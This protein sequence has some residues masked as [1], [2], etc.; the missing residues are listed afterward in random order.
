M[1]FNGEDSEFLALMG[2]GAK[3]AKK[4]HYPELRRRLFELERVS[5]VLDHAG[6]AIFLISLPDGTVEF[7]NKAAL[8]LLGLER[9]TEKRKL[10]EYLKASD[11]G[12]VTL[13]SLFHSS[14]PGERREI[15]SLLTRRGT[16]RYEA[17]FQSVAKGA[18]RLGTLILRDHEERISAEEKLA[19]TLKT[20][21]EERIRTVSLTASL[22]EMKDSY[23]GRNQRG[24][25]SLAREIGSQLGLPN[26][27]IDDL[28]TA[29]LLH[30]VGMMGIPTEVLCIPGPLRPVD[31]RL[32]QEH[33]E[34]GRNL[35]AREGFSE[36]ILDGALRHHERMDGSGYPGGLRGEDIPFIAR[37]IGLAD[38][39]EAMMNHRPYRP[40]HSRESTMR[41][42]AEGRGSLYDPTVTDICLSL[43][44]SGFSFSEEDS[45]PHPSAR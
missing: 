12:T 44:E 19:K 40:A 11:G 30:D 9:T 18:R 10:W 26:D 32:M 41:E 38:V 8:G 31:R 22:V 2:L 4:S 1:P 43:L 37:V 27:E 14:T 15:I 3:S 7:S 6:D 17:S 33:P 29:S 28:A 5:D 42:L 45:L 23:T 36:P 16:R 35:L 13:T 25:A 21:D 24:V 39:V 34:I 20:V